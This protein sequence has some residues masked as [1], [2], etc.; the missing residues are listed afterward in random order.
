[1][2][3]RPPKSEMHAPHG[4]A[5][6]NYRISCDDAQASALLST[7]RRSLARRIVQTRNCALVEKGVE[8]GLVDLS[9]EN[10]R[11]HGGAKCNCAHKR[12]AP[13][14]TERMAPLPSMSA[15][16]TL[17]YKCTS[18]RSRPRTLWKTLRFNA[19]GK[20][21]RSWGKRINIQAL[22]GNNE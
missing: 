21:I 3:A 12:G 22:Q 16:T 6:R 14:C 4:A 19:W 1:M 18:D 11:L 8:N 9:L 20:R 2:I 10:G 5:S 15:A 17:A 7:P 13:S